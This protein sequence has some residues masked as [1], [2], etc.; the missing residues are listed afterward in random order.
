MESLRKHEAKEGEYS[1]MPSMKKLYHLV[2]NGK[3]FSPIH[4]KKNCF[5]FHKANP[6]KVLGTLTSNEIGKKWFF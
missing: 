2:K 3:S 5:N 6:K 1:V 4:P